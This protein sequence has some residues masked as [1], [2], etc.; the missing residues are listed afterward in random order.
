ME[1]LFFSAKKPEIDLESLMCKNSTSV[2]AT[3]TIHVW[4]VLD[5]TQSEEK[6]V[7]IDLK[8]KEIMIQFAGTDKLRIKPV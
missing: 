2:L 1:N 5:K 7:V 4:W 3:E 8:S 6:I